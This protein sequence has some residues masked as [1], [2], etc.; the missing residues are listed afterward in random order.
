M[1]GDPWSGYHTLK[2]ARPR[3]PTNILQMR[4]AF[5]NH[6]E[7]LKDREGEP[8]VVEPIGDAPVGFTGD[9]LQAWKDLVDGCPAGVLTKADRLAVEIA[10]G[11]LH[12]HRVM[13]LSGSDLSQLTNLLGR[14]GMTPSDRSKVRVSVPTPSPENPFGKL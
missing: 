8:K 4:G 14:F 12:R 13:P 6:P 11:L 7:R 5:K 1:L 9:L 3:T 10:A 2:M